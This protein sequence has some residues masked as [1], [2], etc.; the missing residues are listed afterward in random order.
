MFIFV[1][2][3]LLNSILLTYKKYFNRNYFFNVINQNSILILDIRK[4]F[5][6]LDINSSQVLKN[7]LYRTIPFYSTQED[8]KG[9]LTIKMLSNRINLNDLYKNNKINPSISLFLDKLFEKYGILDPLFLKNLL[10]P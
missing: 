4:Y 1:I 7:L 6:Q 10:F 5:S 9:I 3:V 8:F 2:F